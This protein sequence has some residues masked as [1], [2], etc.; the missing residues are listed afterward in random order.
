[1]ANELQEPNSPPGAARTRSESTLG[2]KAAEGDPDT[3][4]GLTWRI[5]RAATES[6]ANMIRVSILLIFMCTLLLLLA[7]A[8][9]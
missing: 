1:M 3:W 4:C 7:H 8:Q 5:V 2:A 9:H 6:N